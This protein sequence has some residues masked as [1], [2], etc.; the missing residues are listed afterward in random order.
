M[1]STNRNRRVIHIYHGK[2]V[3]KVYCDRLGTI[4]QNPHL[5]I[6]VLHVGLKILIENIEY[7]LYSSRT[8]VEDFRHRFTVINMNGTSVPIGQIHSFHSYA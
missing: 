7:A 2:S 5:R 8:L 4:I 1:Y 3:T 6:Y